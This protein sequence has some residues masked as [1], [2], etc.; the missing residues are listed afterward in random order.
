MTIDNLREK[1]GKFLYGGVHMVYAT[2]KT[3]LGVSQSDRIQV[4]L[5][6]LY[7]AAP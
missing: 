4:P 5:I 7:S 1:I 3:S 2:L 6:W